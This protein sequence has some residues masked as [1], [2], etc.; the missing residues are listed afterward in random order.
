MCT[1]K[2]YGRRHGARQSSLQN[3][4]ASVSGGSS[5]VPTPRC[6]RT[7]L[8]TP[9]TGGHSGLSVSWLFCC[10]LV[11][12]VERQ[13]KGQETRTERPQDGGHCSTVAVATAVRCGDGGRTATAA[14]LV[15]MRHPRE[16]RPHIQ[17]LTH[18]ECVGIAAWPC[19]PCEPTMARRPA[20]GRCPPEATPVLST[21]SSARGGRRVPAVLSVQ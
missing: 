11:P 2:Q 18:N 16:R 21:L 12:C 17:S 14:R 13:T 19:G 1:C 5:T 20:G 9:Q 10:G 6:P 7:M 15:S 4:V 8:G 3:R